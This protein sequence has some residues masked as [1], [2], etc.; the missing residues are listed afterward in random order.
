MTLLRQ[1]V[2]YGS[3]TRACRKAEELRLTVFK[4]KMLRKIHGSIFDSQTD[5][6]KQFQDNEQQTQFQRSNAI[7]REY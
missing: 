7:K 4:R 3:K 1:I 2:L 6:W 5:E